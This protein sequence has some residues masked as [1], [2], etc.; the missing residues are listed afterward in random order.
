MEMSRHQR[1]SL[2]IQAL[3]LWDNSPKYQENPQAALEYIWNDF[4]PNPKKLPLSDFEDE[5]FFGVIDHNEDIKKKLTK[6]AP[7][8][9]L[10]RIASHDRAVLYLGIFELIHTDVPTPVVMN[11]S[12]ELAKEYGG[13]KSSKFIN[14]VLSNINKITS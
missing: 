14:A 3:F 8:W 6:A 10:D 4:C 5:R 12:I 1:R 7:D 9:P 13:D 2:L 11:E